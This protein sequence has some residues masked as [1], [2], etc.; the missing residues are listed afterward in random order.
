VSSVDQVTVEPEEYQKYLKMAYEE[1]FPKGGLKKLDF[2]TKTPPEEMRSRLLSTIQ[3][4][5]EDLRS[6]AFEWA[7]KVKE[8]LLE[9]GKIEPHRLFL[10]EPDVFSP[11]GDAKSKGCGVLL[12]LK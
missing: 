3:V 2:I 7:M 12:K 4:T 5:D 9:S 8:R 6:L 11:A 1:E 10:L